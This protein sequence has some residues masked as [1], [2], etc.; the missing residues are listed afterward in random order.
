MDDH[1]SRGDDGLAAGP[2]LAARVRLNAPAELLVFGHTF[3]GLFQRAL[4]GRLDAKARQRLEQA[5]L[6]LGKKLLP[7][8]P[9]DVWMRCIAIAAES[10]YPALPQTEARRQIGRDLVHGYRETYLG[11]AMLALAK[12]LGPKRTLQ[13]SAHN[14]RTGNN[15]TETRLT[16]RAPN[17][18]ELWM[19]EVGPYPEFTQGI[20]EAGLLEAG[21]RGLKVDVVWHDGHGATYRVSW[22]D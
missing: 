8:Y 10:V 3:E 14:F 9:F 17:V 1:S 2:S 7:A 22:D 21:A 13:R 4:G 16:E 20:I 11:R 18:H 12:V 5:G 15:Y 19:N 6:N